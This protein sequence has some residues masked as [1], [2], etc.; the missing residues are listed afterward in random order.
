MRCYECSH[1]GV[2][3]E[4]IGICHHCSAALY[5]D[6]A[7]VVVDPVTTHYPVARTVT[8]P[9]KARVLLCETCRTAL[10]Q[11]HFLKTA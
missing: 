4:A 7:S 2:A 3:R 11:P 5:S 8:L 1:G 6:H 9:K 10:K